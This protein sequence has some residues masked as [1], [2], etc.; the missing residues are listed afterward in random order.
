MI[1]DI[2]AK[3]IADGFERV[4]VKTIGG[5]SHGKISLFYEDSAG[6]VG[7][8]SCI[9]CNTVKVVD[10]F[11]KDKSKRGGVRGECRGCVSARMKGYFSRPDV[12]QRQAAYKAEYYRKNKEEIAEYWAEYRQRNADAIAAQKA[13]YRRNNPEIYALNDAR[14]RAR[15]AALPDTWTIEQRNSMM[16]QFNGACYITGSTD[17][18]L[19]HTTPVSAPNVAFNGGTSAGNLLP[20]DST[21]NLRKSDRNAFEFI[22]SEYKSG[23]IGYAELQ[24]FLRGI[25]YLATQDGMT[26][27]QKIFQSMMAMVN[28]HEHDLQANEQLASVFYE[29]IDLIEQRQT[30]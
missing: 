4:E 9:T 1:T 17:V 12:K 27:E 20:M 7:G 3:L 16:N 11:P 2:E 13:E 29:G 15:K 21:M 14:R 5:K 25:D 22:M 18:H 26:S 10:E 28:I 30:E 23:S 8:R 19:E 24:N 6:N